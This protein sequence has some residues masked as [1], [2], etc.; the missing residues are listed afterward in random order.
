MSDTGVTIPLYFSLIYG[1]ARLLGFIDT[2]YDW[3]ILALL[4]I[5]DV[6]AHKGGD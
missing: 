5:G 3:L 2:E 1:V 6:I 4:Y